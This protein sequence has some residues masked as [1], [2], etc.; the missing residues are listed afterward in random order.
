MLMTSHSKG[1]MYGAFNFP[2]IEC[3]PIKYNS[4]LAKMA[5]QF[6]RVPELLPAE[7]SIVSIEALPFERAN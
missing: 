5:A 2:N 1:K 6:P 7:Q 3:K 4:G